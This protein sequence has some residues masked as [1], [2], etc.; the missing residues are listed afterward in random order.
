MD[1]L[2]DR[3]KRKFDGKLYRRRT[4]YHEAGHAVLG[5]ILQNDILFARINSFD[6]DEALAGVTR[7][8]GEYAPHLL[9]FGEAQYQ[10]YI[11]LRIMK[12]LAGYVAQYLYPAK[13]ADSYYLN[14]MCY[15]AL[16]QDDDGDE[17][18]PDDDTRVYSDY[19]KVLKDLE[20]LM[21]FGSQEEFQ[22]HYETFLIEKCRYILQQQPIWEALK[23]VAE[24]LLDKLEMTGEEIYTACYQIDGF[25]ATCE[26]LRDIYLG[27]NNFE[28]KKN[29]LSVHSQTVSF[30]F[31]DN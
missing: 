7:V 11:E 28:Q 17:F 27:K 1:N 15:L 29:G 24:T 23:I 25:A 5:V 10:K 30:Q 19:S 9:P 4:A 2:Q 6:A 13:K 20:A 14:E 22:F 18:N 16:T 31:F 21:F 26:K 8:W 12:N 3:V